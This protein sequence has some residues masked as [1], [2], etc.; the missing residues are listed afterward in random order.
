MKKQYVIPQMEIISTRSEQLLDGSLSVF[1]S[2]A[3]DEAMSKE[4]NRQD[5]SSTENE[6]GGLW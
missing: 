3:T 1:S 4:R 2:D 5:F 6:W